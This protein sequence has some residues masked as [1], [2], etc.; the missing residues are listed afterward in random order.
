[1][2]DVKAGI[3]SETSLE[4]E[5]HASWI[6]LFFDLVVVAGVGTLAHVIHDDVTGASLA[7]YAVLFLAFWLSWMSYMLYGNAAG[8]DTRTV[9]LLMGMFGLAVMAASVPGVAEDVVHEGF[10]GAHFAMANAFAIAYVA[11]RFAGAGAWRRGAVVADWPIA[12]HL[13]GVV[14]WVVSI[15]VD[16]PWKFALWALGIALDLVLLVVMSGED[17]LGETQK[18]VDQMTQRSP[19]RMTSF[20]GIQIVR[21]DAGHL[22]ERLSCSSSSCSARGSSRA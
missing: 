15:W 10:E 19:E 4:E 20:A 11:T 18:R 22:S 5:R 3:G 2:D 9:R 14:P 6:E 17:M 12:Q 7:L 13:T 1:M 8:E 16:E 21:F